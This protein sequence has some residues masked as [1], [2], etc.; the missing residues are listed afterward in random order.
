MTPHRAKILSILLEQGEIIDQDGQ[1]TTLLMQET[2]HRTSNALSGVLLA[3]EQAGLI[4]RDKA[5]R[6][7]YRIALTRQGRKLAQQL[8]A[9]T[10]DSPIVETE[11]PGGDLIDMLRAALVAVR[12]GEERIAALEARVAALESAGA[13]APGTAR[14]T[15]KE[16]AELRRLMPASRR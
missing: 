11:E 5:G 2:G 3:M 8:A 10:A 9:G 15:A 13:P 1:S 7:T 16:L 6:R 4:E 14:V 12:E